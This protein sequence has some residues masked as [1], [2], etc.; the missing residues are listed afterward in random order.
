MDEFKNN[1]KNLL[2]HKI[3]NNP[4][5]IIKYLQIGISIPVW[6]EFYEF[7]LHDLNFFN[8]RS[9]I[10]Y[11]NGNPA[12]HVLLYDSGREKLY[13]GYFGVINHKKKKIEFLIKKMLDF[14]RV[15]HYNSIRGPI[16]I[17]TII[18]GW[19]FHELLAM[20]KMCSNYDPDLCVGSY[21]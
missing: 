8:A 9:L 15:N 14:T 19:G 4:L 16:N 7:I 18:F 13:F 2:T 11:E 5:E 6:S 20:R 10:I 21:G 3:I 12:G 17:P 1:G